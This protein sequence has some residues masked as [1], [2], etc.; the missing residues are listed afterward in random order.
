MRPVI[1]L[2][3]DGVIDRKAP[4]GEYIR[5]WDGFAFLPGA[6][7]ALARLSSPDGPALVVVTN[8]RGIARGHMSQGDVDRI[9]E[10]MLGAL[11]EHGVSIDA[12]HVCPHEV[13]QCHCRKPEIGLFLEAMRRDPSLDRTRAAFVGDSLSDIQAGRA[14]G[15]PTYL[16]CEDEAPILGQARQLGLEIA[17][18]GA[19]LLELVESHAFDRLMA[20][21]S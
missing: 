3:R 17:G 11:A 21:A 19:S 9:H 4:A 18:V 1:F 14:L 7:E 20:V 16:V 5:D 12:V 2:D 8:Q 6:I 15:I 13:G 10:R